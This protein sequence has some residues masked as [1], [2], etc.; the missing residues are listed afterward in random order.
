V[1]KWL[2]E[3]EKLVSQLFSLARE[4]APSIVFID[5]VCCYAWRLSCVSCLCFMNLGIH[6]GS[7]AS[8]TCSRA[9]ILLGEWQGLTTWLVWR[10]STHCAAAEGTARARRRGASRRSSWCRCRASTA[11]TRACSSWAPPTCPTPSTRP[12]DDDLTGSV[13]GALCL[14]LQ[15]SLERHVSRQRCPASV[16]LQLVL[17]SGLSRVGLT[18]LGSLKWWS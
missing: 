17:M 16:L 4:K 3:S 6:D 10:R 2:G 12:S 8:W 14:F 11:M 13:A 15:S 9:N 5:E 18:I 1:S 7:R